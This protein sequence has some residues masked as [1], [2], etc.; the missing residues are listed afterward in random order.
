M[1]RAL[2]F[3]V[4]MT[5][6]LAA[7][8]PA[9][10][11]PEKQFSGQ[12]LILKK[13]APSRFSNSSAFT[14]FLRA[15]RIQDVWPAAKGS[16]SWRLEFMAFF[17]SPISDVDVKVRFFDVTSE[18][19]L[20]AADSVFTSARGQRILAS[21]FVLEQ[22]EFQV[23]RKYLMVVSGGRGPAKA[24]TT[25]FTLRGKRQSYNGKVVFSEEEAR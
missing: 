2:L 6:G 4:A 17:R 22:P 20:V 7:G 10:A 3:L 18:K 11:S 24:A 25:R 23:D 12:V 13:R 14:R 21:S 19:K 1:R 15:N 16:S 9:G 8:L 5:F